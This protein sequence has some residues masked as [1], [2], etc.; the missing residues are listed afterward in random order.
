MIKNVD[1]VLFGKNEPQWWVNN[2]NK[3]VLFD[4]KNYSVD[5]TKSFNYYNYLYSYKEAFQFLKDYC[6]ENYDKSFCKNIN[7]LDETNVPLWIGWVSRMLVNGCDKIPKEMLERFKSTLEKL[8]NHSKG[9][10]VEQE[11]KIPNHWKDNHA[12]SKLDDYIENFYLNYH[13]PDNIHEEL[14]SWKLS[15]KEYSECRRVVLELYNE[16]LEIKNC[17]QL[18]EAF[19]NHSKKQIK[20]STDFYKQLLEGLDKLI[21][22]NKTVRV[23]KN[24]K[25]KN[26]PDIPLLLQ[27]EEY[28]IKSIPLKKC[29]GIDIEK[30]IIYNNISRNLSVIY[31]GDDYIKLNKK[32]TNVDTVNSYSLILRNPKEQLPN[33]IGKNKN[34]LDS[35]IDNEIKS[36]KKPPQLKF[37]NNTIILRV[38]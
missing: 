8:C 17:E 6:K 21:I 29:F 18:Q 1:Q 35:F 9:M 16:M 27:I 33:I 28:A 15:S 31:K 12:M 34:S 19:R 30:I 25:I 38:M 2:A 4:N 20:N 32:I 22:V 3:N 10:K 14:I 24:K 11:Y 5:I 36:K 13:T 7:K 23:S 26:I 37:D